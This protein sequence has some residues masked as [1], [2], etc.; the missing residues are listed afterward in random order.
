MERRILTYAPGFPPGG[1]I[2][3]GNVGLHYFE[4]RY[5]LNSPVRTPVRPW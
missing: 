3:Q 5:G 2:Q 1:Q 4:W